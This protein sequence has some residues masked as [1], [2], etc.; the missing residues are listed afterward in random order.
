MPD[1]ATLTVAT[2]RVTGFEEF[3]AGRTVR[4]EDSSLVRAGGPSPD[5]VLF[6]YSSVQAGRVADVWARYRN[7]TPVYRLD[8]NLIPYVRVYRVQT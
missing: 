8:I 1:A 7:A 3:F 2:T 5:L 4:I 6:Y